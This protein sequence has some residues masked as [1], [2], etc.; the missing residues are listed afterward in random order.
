MALALKPH[1]L[2]LKLDV[3]HRER[4]VGSSN[5]TNIGRLLVGIFDGTVIFVIDDRDI[6]SSITYC[7]NNALYFNLMFGNQDHLDNRHQQDHFV[8]N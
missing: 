4:A 7:I 3:N 2:V 5:Y 8:L 1:V 6:F